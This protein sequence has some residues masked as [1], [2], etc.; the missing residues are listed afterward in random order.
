MTGK[1]SG[2]SLSRWTHDRISLWLSIAD[3]LPVRAPS[4]QS[5]GRFDGTVV[6]FPCYDSCGASGAFTWE[7]RRSRLALSS[8]CISDAP[9]ERTLASEESQV[10]E[11]LSNRLRWTARRLRQGRRLGRSMAASA[12]PPSERLWPARGECGSARNTGNRTSRSATGR[13]H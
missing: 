13:L 7:C 1:A 11:P 8:S 4:P 6:H 5:R 2:G 9:Q 3:C 10:D 12:V